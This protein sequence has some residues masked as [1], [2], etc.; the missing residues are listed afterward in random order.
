M[1]VN[2]T[3]ED[4]IDPKLNYNLQ[5]MILHNFTTLGED[6]KFNPKQPITRGEAAVWVHNA[7]QFVESHA[8]KPPVQEE[9]K[10]S[11]EKVNDAVNKIVL[12]RG[13]KPTGGYGIAINS[14]RFEQ[15]GKAIISYTLADPSPDS[16]NTQV[17]TVPTAHTYVSSEYSV[18]AEPAEAS[19][20][21]SS[22]GIVH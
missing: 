19:G 15:D 1:L 18:T 8:E 5:R 16:M 10:V 22:T 4:Q 11:V 17:I 6:G 7:I 13:E 12:S 20:S 9:I 3:D 14:V 21:S 2:F